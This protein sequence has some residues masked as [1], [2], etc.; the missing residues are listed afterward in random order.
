MPSALHG[1]A[2]RDSPCP[3][4]SCTCCRRASPYICLQPRLAGWRGL[5][6]SGLQEQ[7]QSSAVAARA[8]SAARPLG[9]AC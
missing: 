9:G 3:A 4:S 1:P 8:R 5:Q 6:P 2:A 7:F